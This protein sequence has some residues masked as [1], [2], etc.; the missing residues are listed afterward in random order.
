M[1]DRQA[2]PL[3]EEIVSWAKK[4]R[5]EAFLEKLQDAGFDTMEVLS[6]I[7]PE[8]LDWMEIIRPGDRKKIMIAVRSIETQED[9]EESEEVTVGTEINEII[10]TEELACSDRP[11]EPQIL[12]DMMTALSPFLTQSHRVVEGN[13]LYHAVCKNDINE[14][15]KLV[16][17][18]KEGN[19]II[20]I[21][22]Q[23]GTSK[24]TV[25]HTAVSMGSNVSSSYFVQLFSDSLFF[26][27]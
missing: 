17:Q 5:I 16:K 24:S 2:I 20:D 27:F 7:E 21:N 10:N 14:V 15:T 4:Y 8:D 19:S 13:Q 12:L 22:E 23:C 9:N 25:L 11:R 18:I 6:Q 1:G 26:F 3:C